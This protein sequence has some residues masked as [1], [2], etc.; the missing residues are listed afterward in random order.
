MAKHE[1]SIRYC[2]SGLTDGR[3]PIKDLAP[4]LL[5]L[6]ESFQEIQSFM[7]PDQQP[8]SLD[9]KATEK[10]S[11]IA[12]LI[13]ANGK[14][15]LSHTI[16][17]LTGKEAEAT[18]TLIE[19]VGGFA[20]LITFIKTVGDKKLKSK[21]ELKNGEVKIT[22][23]DNSSISV[24]ENV[25]EAFQS[26]EIR[27]SIKEFVKPLESNGI[28]GIELMEEKNIKFILTKEDVPSFEVPPTKERELEI[29][30]STTYLQ[31]INVSFAEE[32]WKFT[33]GNKPF[34]AKVEDESFLSDIQS[35]KQQFG[36][37]D[38]L[39]VILETRQKISDNGLKSEY[40]VTKVLEHIKGSMQMELMFE[41]ED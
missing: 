25:F 30:S 24:P 39:K 9:I 31:I 27:K 36:A 35:S 32:K 28:S 26:I 15:I 2:G 4:S 3:I 29:A 37:N 33:D 16:D 23:D 34:F 14:D 10:G 6:S 18:K 40:T 20:A 8:V 22:M 21:E 5:S 11:F 38:A 17:L 19:L 12:D 13:L 7:Y 41:D 1:F